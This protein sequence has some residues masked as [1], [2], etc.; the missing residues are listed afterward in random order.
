MQDFFLLLLVKKIETFSTNCLHILS[1][2]IDQY[3]I[4]TKYIAWRP[5][6]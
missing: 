5:L 4:P 2:D 6:H 3:P 1:D